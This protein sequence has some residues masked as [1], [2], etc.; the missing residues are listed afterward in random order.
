MT[1]LAA[2]VGINHWLD[3]TMPFAMSVATRNPTMTTLVI[4]N[5]SEPPYPECPLWQTSRID[6]CG[7]NH[8]LNHALSYEADWYVLF[9]NDCMA[10]R[11]FENV[12][13][14]LDKRTLYGSGW[15]WCDN[16]Q[17]QMLYSAWLCMSRELVN[18]VGLFDPQLD[19]GFEDFD[20]QMRCL[21]KGIRLEVLRLDIDHLDKHTRFEERAYNENWERCRVYFDKKWHTTTQPWKPVKK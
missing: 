9:N 1:I 7:Y 6:R 11:E 5:G 12:I 18:E 13:P 20:Y 14:T 10:H 15:Q 17:R 21:D 16:F 3:L 4:D 19:A 8:A 2:I